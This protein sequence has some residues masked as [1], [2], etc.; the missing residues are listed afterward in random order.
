MP[1]AENHSIDLWGGGT[2]GHVKLA[3][4]L[5]QSM[6]NPWGL[7]DRQQETPEKKHLRDFKAEAGYAE[8]TVFGEGMSGNLDL[9]C[10]IQFHW[11]Y[12]FSFGMSGQRCPQCTAKIL[13]D[14]LWLLHGVGSTPK[15]S[16]DT[17]RCQEGFWEGSGV[18][19]GFLEGGLAA[20]LQWKRVLRRVVR[21]SS[22]KGVPR[23]YVERRL[24]EYEPLGVR[25]M[26]RTASQKGRFQPYRGGHSS[27][28]RGWTSATCM[29]SC[30]SPWKN[31]FLTC[32]LGMSRL[33]FN[34]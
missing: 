31:L 9:Q 30:T 14:Q 32:L 33:C 11:L 10:G 6:W 17:T 25:P 1:N 20:G 19:E 29:C 3:R 13:Y 28:T 21:R 5:P 27:E 15:G 18:S 24:G 12:V 16:Y 7:W 4:C 26:E 22:K 34:F 23:R 2:C 8:K